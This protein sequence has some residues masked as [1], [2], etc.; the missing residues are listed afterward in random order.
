THINQ[1]QNKQNNDY[2]ITTDLIRHLIFCRHQYRKI[3][4][5]I[6]EALVDYCTSDKPDEFNPF[7]KQLLVQDIRCTIE[8]SLEHLIRLCE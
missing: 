1:F 6:D 5:F 8:D 2:L 3:I 4:N 7:Q